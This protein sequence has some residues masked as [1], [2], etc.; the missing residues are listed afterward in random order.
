VYDFFIIA[1]KAKRLLYTFLSM[2]IILFSLPILYN[3]RHKDQLQVIF[4]VDGFFIG[5]PY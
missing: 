4:R 2:S 5:I 3:V 1:S